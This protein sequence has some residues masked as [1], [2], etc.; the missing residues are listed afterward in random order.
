MTSR[1]RS[2][3]DVIVVGSRCAGAS[4]AMLLARAG[5]DV[6]VVDRA[7]FPSDT[8]STH[9]I[10]RGGVVQ[11]ARWGLLDAVLDGGAPAVRQV[12]FG[13][14]DTET[15]RAIKDRSG[16]DM[17]VAPRRYALDALLVDAALDAGATV[18]TGITA[19]GVLRN[20][21]GRVTGIVARTAGGDAIELTARYVVGADGLRSR[22]A[23]WVGATTVESFAADTAT[24]YCYVGDVPWRGHEFHLAPEAFAGVFLTHGGEACV[25]LCRPTPALESVRRAGADRAAAL[26]HQLHAVSPDLAARI[27]AGRVTSSVRGMAGL[28]NHFREPAGPGWALVGDAGYHRDPITGHGITDAFRDAELLARA[29]DRSLRDPAAEHGAMVEYRERRRAMARET[30]DLTRQM[31]AFPAPSRFLEL[32][33]Q[34]SDALEREAE[35]LASFPSPAEPAAMAA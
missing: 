28:P 22:T 21:T 2:H 13:S 23:G 7:S 34:L 1:L 24:F 32:Q 19:T 35:L 17:L 27:R 31:A 26:V 5:H 8:V 30:F 15:T 16:V 9:S 12:T 3:H 11:L 33:K 29:L 6:A 14:G 25:W 4:T 20:A 18:S 10:A